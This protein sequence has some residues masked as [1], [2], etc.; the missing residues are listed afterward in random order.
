[1]TDEKKDRLLELLAEQ[2][3]FG[4]NEQE[5]MELNQLKIQFPDWNSLDNFETAA[6]AI[7]LSNL[8]IVLCLIIFVQKF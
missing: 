3:L 5:L 1:M 4:L 6:V 2:M 8:N 7:S